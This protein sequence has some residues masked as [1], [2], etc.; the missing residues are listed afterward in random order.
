MK[1]EKLI[2]MAFFV[3]AGIMCILFFSI[4]EQALLNDA[5]AIQIAKDEAS[6]ET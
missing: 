2:D 1:N 4:V 5:R 3:W 6:N